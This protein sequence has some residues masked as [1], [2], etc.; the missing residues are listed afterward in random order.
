MSS[1]PLKQGTIKQIASMLARHIVNKSQIQ[2]YLL[3]ERAHPPY[4]L[5]IT[6]LAQNRQLFRELVAIGGV[7]ARNFTEQ[8]DEYDRKPTGNDDYMAK[9]HY[10][11]IIFKTRHLA[12]E[13][14]RTLVDMLCNMAVPW[15]SVEVM[16]EEDVEL[17]RMHSY[18]I[19]VMML[20]IC[21]RPELADGWGAWEDAVLDA[22][23]A[24][25]TP[26]GWWQWFAGSRR[27][28]FAAKLREFTTQRC[29]MLSAEQREYLSTVLLMV[30]PPPDATF[31]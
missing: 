27:E 25:R 26:G 1:E 10:R 22:C 28:L 15:N 13:E 21:G 20:V 5:R 4:A 11:S 18:V 2:A 24:V 9:H 16:E 6:K 3:N 14:F 17:N 7:R 30:L 19:N 31:M 12:M 29:P 23:T 8:P